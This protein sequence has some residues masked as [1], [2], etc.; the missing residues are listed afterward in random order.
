MAYFDV[1]SPYAAPVCSRTQPASAWT[2]GA[3]TATAHA[4]SADFVAVPR[5]SFSALEWSVIALSQRDTLGSLR[6][7][8]R[9]SRAFGGL[10]GRGTASRLADPKLEALRRVAV[11]AR[12]RGFALPVT[13]ISNFHENG[14]SEAQMET[15]VTSMT[16]M[17]L[18]QTTRRVS[19]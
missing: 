7:P 2:A 1:T 6:T 16:G 8:S 13:E 9:V 17:R 18:G 19:A 10:F 3:Q 11:Y 4:A 15:L 12:H 5:A 14:F